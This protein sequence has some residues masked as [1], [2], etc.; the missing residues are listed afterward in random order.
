MTDRCGR[1]SMRTLPRVMVLA[2]AAW[3]FAGPASAQGCPRGYY[4]AANGGCYRGPQPA[5][6]PPVYDYAPPVYQPPPVYDGFALGVGL[7]ALFGGLANDNGRGR[8]VRGR[9]APSREERGRPSSYG[10]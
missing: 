3:A 6:A 10:R 7:G 9:R 1:Y 8:E 2:L 4:L 5:Y